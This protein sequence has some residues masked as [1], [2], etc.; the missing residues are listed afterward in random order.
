MSSSPRRPLSTSWWRRWDS[1]SL[2]SSSASAPMLRRYS[3]CCPDCG[4]FACFGLVFKAFFISFEVWTFLKLFIIPL[5]LSL[6]LPPWRVSPSQLPLRFNDNLVLR[7]LRYTGMLE[8]VRI[9]QSGYNIK[10]S[11]KVNTCFTPW[12]CFLHGSVQNS[13]WFIEILQNSGKIH[14]SVSS[15]QSV[16]NLPLNYYAKGGWLVDGLI[17]W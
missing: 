8:T 6:S 11:F 1:L 13:F 4:C 15:L 7:Q 5:P 17:G 9:R 10:Y 12:R 16:Q 2:T 3:V 14:E